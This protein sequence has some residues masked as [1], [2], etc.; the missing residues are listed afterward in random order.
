[1]AELL[2]DDHLARERSAAVRSLLAQPLLDADDDPDAFRLV[3]RH[4]LWLIEYFELTCGWVLTVDVASGFARLA[5]RAVVLDVTRPL[6][7][8]RGE[9][10]P[11]DRRRYQLLCLIC[12]E[13]VRHPVTT[14]GLLASAIAGVAGLDTSRYG[15]RAAFVD[16]LRALRSWGALR[17]TS[18]EVDAFL[19]ND[20]ANAILAADTARL[21]RLLVSP[22]APSTLPDQLCVD[23]VI[24]RLLDEPRYGHLVGSDPDELSD[25]ARNRSARHRLGRRLLDDPTVHLDDLSCEERDYLA[26]LSGRRW[27]RD[28]VAEAGFELEERSEGLLAVD[29]EAIATDLRFPAPLGHAYQLALLLADRLVSVGPDGQRH[30]G[31][32][33]PDQLRSEV[34]DVFRR[35]PGWARGQRDEG[36]PARLGR[37]AINLLVAFGLVRRH[38]DGTVVARPALARYTV[39]EAVVPNVIEEE[40]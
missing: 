9:A 25:E 27:L 5:K 12:A 2:L 14:I 1:V 19:D 37:E 13:L 26:S 28:R 15:A 20:R 35:F 21:H 38:P 36:G 34:E 4:G 29:P 33:E 3:V 23:E 24:E 6:R 22:T 7:R 17:A 32:L 11:F 31:R 10:A 16:A 40:R 8:T 39:A 30:L 18:G